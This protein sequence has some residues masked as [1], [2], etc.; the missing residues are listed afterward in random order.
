MNMEHAP[1]RILYLDDEEHNLT[2]FKAAFRREYEVY[3]ATTASEGH[4]ILNEFDIQVVIAD[5]RMPGT[6]GVEFLNQLSR[7][8]P[9]PSV[10]CLPAIPMW[11]P[12][13]MPLISGRYTVT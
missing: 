3:T 6:T 4:L 7:I 2:A 12:L 11:K 8:T 5:Q 10:S 9:I 1:I 13:S